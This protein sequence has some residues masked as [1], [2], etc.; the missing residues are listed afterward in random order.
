MTNKKLN[1]ICVAGFGYSGSGALINLLEEFENFY[2]FPREFRL[3]KDPDGISDL[4]NA[5]VNNWQELKSDIA[6]RRFKFLIDTFG[7]KQNLFSKIGYN[8]DEVLNK[9]F[10]ISCEK[11]LKNLINISWKGDWPFHLHELNGLKFFIYRLMRKLNLNP[12]L[13]DNMFFSKPGEDFYSSTK[14]FFDDLFSKIN[15]N[16]HNYHTIVL[17]QGIDPYNAHKCSRYFN[18]VKAIVVDRDP[19]D[20]YIELCNF[21]SYP[22]NSVDDFITF[23]SNQREAVNKKY[24]SKIV[25][26]LKFENLVN[27]YENEVKKIYSFIGF[28]CKNH[29]KKFERFNPSI[30]NKNIGL[31]KS[32]ISS[33][34]KLIEK[35]LNKY[36]YKN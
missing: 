7:K 16:C 4:E 5:L 20:I 24:D 9:N 10:F 17:D 21:S 12:E 13:S 32:N 11:Y 35:K 34:I 30:S 31:W 6:I 14:V 2:V 18:N 27:N 29:L 23:F 8:Y 3:I 1:F 26:R 25:L 19:R 33:D 28:D 36:L 22:T 15:N